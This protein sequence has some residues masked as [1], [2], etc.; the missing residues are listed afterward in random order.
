MTIPFDDS[1][2]FLLNKTN[3]RL[4]AELLRRARVYNVTAEQW[5][6]LNFITQTDGITQAELSDRTLKDKPNINRI[7][8]KL[9]AK[10]LIEKRP[11]PSDKR[12]HRLYVTKAGYR[13]H[14]NLVP[15]VENVLTKAT[16]NISAEEL[17]QLTLILEKI[18][19][20]LESADKETLP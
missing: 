20:N 15:I 18:Y 12:S 3:L 5:G 11:H 2:G 13:L 17:T 6:V 8:E 19:L 10:N 16:A 4:K 1:L 7:I 14:A 9:L